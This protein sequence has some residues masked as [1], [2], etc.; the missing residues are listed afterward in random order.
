M[1]EAV[2]AV[3]AD[4]DSQDRLESL[5]ITH[6][7][8]VFPRYHFSEDW[9]ASSI[10]YFLH[11]DQDRLLLEPS[12][13]K[14]Q[15]LWVDFTAG[16]MG[17]RGQ[18]NVRNEMVVKAV[19]GRDKQKKPSV[20]DATAGLGRDSFL[21]AVLGC[22]VTMIERNPI[23]M[24][25]LADGLHRFQL[26]DDSGVAKRLALFPGDA[27][28][29]LSQL[30]QSKSADVVYLD[31]MFP[32]RE[33]SALVKKEMQ[34]FRDIVGLDSDSDELLLTAKQIARDRVVV[35]RAS[36]AEYL[37]NIK[38]TYSLT[39]RSSRFDIYQC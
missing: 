16:S 37:A 12:D 15:P 6:L 18:Q 29:Q 27:K 4:I 21:L 24:A 17:Y 2:V 36:K 19:L 25:L 35:K 3:S 26:Q 5:Q 22:Q 10:P 13:K 20:I 30:A 1:D 14:R 9:L 34:I 8:T 38:P 31:P 39:G 33:K 7:L 28:N 11:I 23:V 32:K